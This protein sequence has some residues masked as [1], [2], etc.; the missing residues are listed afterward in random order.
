M[1]FKL[2]GF[3]FAHNRVS[4]YQ[5]FLNEIF[6]YPYFFVVPRFR[7]NQKIAISGM[8]IADPQKEDGA[9][10]AGV[11][12]LLGVGRGVRVG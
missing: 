9:F 1:D 2:R 12:G 5:V 6:D 7:P 11:G 10:G 8:S 4:L 3:G